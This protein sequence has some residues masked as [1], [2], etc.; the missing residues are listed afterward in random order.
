MKQE[1]GSEIASLIREVNATLNAQL[2]EAFKENDLTPPQMMVI[3]MLAE[4]KKLKVSEISTKMNLANS[5]VSGII[6]RLEKSGYVKRMRSEVDRRV[7]HVVLSEQVEELHHSFHETVTQFLGTIA[8]DATNE[9]I[10]QVLTGLNTLRTLLSG[11]KTKNLR[12]E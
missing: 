9:Q 5:T 4:E 12:C 2:R 8:A 1:S 3:F 10:E 6:D 7:V 11:K